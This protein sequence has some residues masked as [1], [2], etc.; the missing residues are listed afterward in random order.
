MNGL[1]S[2]YKHTSPSGKVYIGITS[3]DPKAR[4]KA[5]YKSCVAFYNAI[6]KYGWKNIK[7]EVLFTGLTKEDACAKEIE[8]IA[9]FNSTNP[10]YGYNISK[11]GVATMLGVSVSD[12]IAKV[13]NGQRHFAAG[14][15]W[16][17]K[18]AA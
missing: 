17:L 16:K 2:V 10:K 8:L 14:Y 12:N 13:I 9:Q 6:Q 1:Y 5:G 4:W 15:R 18:E 3:M 11:G 7:S